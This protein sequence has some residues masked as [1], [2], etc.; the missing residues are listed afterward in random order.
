MRLA[1]NRLTLKEPP[2]SIF[3]LSN[4]TFHTVNERLIHLLLQRSEVPVGK[5]ERETCDLRGCFFFSS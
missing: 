2:P 4:H 1:A 3:R 5:L